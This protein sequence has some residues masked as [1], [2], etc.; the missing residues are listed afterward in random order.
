MKFLLP[1]FV[2]QAL[3]DPNCNCLWLKNTAAG[4]YRA[5]NGQSIFNIGMGVPDYCPLCGKIVVVSH[6]KEV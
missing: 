1:P 5:H 6:G 2:Q 3:H 4:L